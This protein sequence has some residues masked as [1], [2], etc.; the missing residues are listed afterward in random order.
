MNTAFDKVSTSTYVVDIFIAG[1]LLE[2]KRICQHYCEHGLCVTVTP[3]DFL[4]TYGSESGA[5][6]GLI[7][8][9]RFPSDAESIECQAFALAERLMLGV[10]QR[11]CSVV[12][13][14]RTY[15][16]TRANAEEV[17]K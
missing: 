16:L 14:D 15:F 9:A 12:T 2:I 5:R 6:I 17:V 10:S 7:N 3:T 8:Y 1:E 13:P 11:S 4:Y